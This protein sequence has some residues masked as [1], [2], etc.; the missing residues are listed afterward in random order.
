MAEENIN[1]QDIKRISDALLDELYSIGSGIRD[2]NFDV[3]SGFADVS[4]GMVKTENTLDLLSGVLGQILGQQEKY[5]QRQE[6]LEAERE[7]ADM[8][9]NTGNNTSTQIADLMK[10]SLAGFSELNIDEKQIEN[11]SGLINALVSGGKAWIDAGLDAGTVETIATGMGLISSAMTQ[12]LSSIP[13]DFSTEGVVKMTAGISGLETLVTEMDTAALSTGLNKVVEVFLDFK[14]NFPADVIG[15][16]NDF[17][18]NLSNIHIELPEGISETLTG[19]LNM[20]TTFRD[21][22]P[23]DALEPINELFRNLNNV[24]QQLNISGLDDI[25]SSVTKSFINF[26]DNFPDDLLTPLN[27]FL[28]DLSDIEQQFPT[29]LADNLSAITNVFIN[30]RDNFPTDIFVSV[31]EFFQR[32]NDM[33][34]N[35]PPE[36]STN[37]NGLLDTFRSFRDNFPTDITGHLNVFMENI[38]SL[39]HQFPENLISDINS[40][41]GTLMTFDREFPENIPDKI[42]ALVTRL[43]AMADEIEEIGERFSTKSFKKSIN[44]LLDVF[45][46]FKKEFPTDAMSVLTDFLK[47]VT[48]LRQGFPKN[49]GADINSLLK[50]LADF[51]KGVSLKNAKKS[52]KGLGEVLAEFMTKIPDEKGDSMKSLATFFA[53]FNRITPEQVKVFRSLRK[54]LTPAVAKSIKGFLD[55]MANADIPDAKQMKGV[56]DVIEAL[57]GAFTKVIVLL[58]VL[59]ILMMFDMNATLVAAATAVG[60]VAAMGGLVAGIAYIL[61]KKELNDSIGVIKS[62]SVAVL[63][64]VAC[65]GMMTLLA[66]VSETGDL[67]WGI[68]ITVG[69]TVLLVGMLHWLST[70]SKDIKDATISILAVSGAVVLLAGTLMFVSLMA[71]ILEATD[72]GWGILLFAVSLIGVGVVLKLTS[73][74]DKPAGEA[75]GALLAVGGMMVLLSISLMMFVMLA[76]NYDMED[77][78]AGILMLSVVVIGAWVL[79]RF[80]KIA[81]DSSKGAIN[82]AL[83]ISILILTLT[84]SL[85]LAVMIAQK[86][87]IGEILGGFAILALVVGMSIGLVWVLNKIGGRD[88]EKAALTMAIVVGLMLVTVGIAILMTYLPPMKD[89]ILEGSLIVGSILLAAVGITFMVA[90]IGKFAGDAM[91]KGVIGL[92]AVIGAIIALTIVGFYFADLVWRFA[93]I[94]WGMIGKTFTVIG[95]LLA[96]VTAILAIC[97][98]LVS[99]PQAA[100][101]GLAILGMYAIIGAIGALVWVTDSYLDLAER[102]SMLDETMLTSTRDTFTNIIMPGIGDMVSSFASLAGWAAVKAAAASVLLMPVFI[103]LGMFVDI[104]AKVATMTFVTGYDADGKPQYTTL[105]PEVFGKAAT[106]VSEGFGKFITELGKGFD[107]L[108]DKSIRAMDRLKWIMIPLMW[109]VSDFVDTV[110]KVATMQIID[111]Y[112]ENGKPKYRQV[113]TTVFSNAAEVVSGGFKD[114]IEKMG[115]GFGALEDKSI[116]A[117]KKLAKPMNKIMGAVKTFVDVVIKVATLRIVEGYDEKGNPIYGELKTRAFTMDENGVISQGEEVTGLAVFAVAGHAVAQSFGS[118]LRALTSA[119]DDKRTVDAIAKGTKAL[120]KNIRPIMKGIATFVDTIIKVATARVVTGYETDEHGNLIP[121][122]DVIKGQKIKVDSQGNIT[123]TGQ[124]EGY[125]AMAAAGETVAIMFTS[126]LN[127]LSSLFESR[128][129]QKQIERCLKSLKNVNPVMKGIGKFVD[130]ILKIATGT[131]PAF[132]ENGNALLDEEGN[133]KMRQINLETDL[134]N[135]AEV[136]AGAFAT[137]LTTL[138]DNLDK[139]KKTIKKVLESLKD[140][141]PVFESVGKFTD[142]IKVIGTGLYPIKGYDEQGNPIYDMTKQVDATSAANTLADTYTTFVNKIT[143][144]FNDES[145]KEKIKN[146]LSVITDTNTIVEKTCT[147]TSKIVEQINKFTGG[148]EG[149]GVKL[150]DLPAYSEKLVTNGIVKFVELFINSETIMNFPNYDMVAK[151]NAIEQ[152]LMA[153]DRGFVIYKRILDRDYSI[154]DNLNPF[155]MFVNSMERFANSTVANNTQ[156]FDKN[157]T[158]YRTCVDQM[159]ESLKKAQADIQKTDTKLQAFDKKAKGY[160]D[161]FVKYVRAVTTEIVNLDNQLIN[162]ERRRKQA[163]ESFA[164]GIKTVADELM[165]LNEQLM[166]QKGFSTMNDIA[167]NFK[168]AAEMMMEVQKSLDKVAEPMKKVAEHQV[169]SYRRPEVWDENR[170]RQAGWEATAR[171]AGLPQSLGGSVETQKGFS[172]IMS[173]PTAQGQM[174]MRFDSNGNMYTQYPDGSSFAIPANV[175]L[176]VYQQGGAE[177]L[178]NPMVVDRVNKDHGIRTPFPAGNQNPGGNGYYAHNPNPGGPADRF[179]AALNTREGVQ[180]VFNFDGYDIKGVMKTI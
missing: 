2:V 176:N 145:Y 16:V 65:I 96:G 159:T 119:F 162:N 62:I 85:M 155:T 108:S 64:L 88:M 109:T 34:T 125:G 157:L 76:K 98:A 170:R 144:T 43:D 148:D 23:A 133:P 51:D 94:E 83:G 17:F 139:N 92:A 169:E 89:D 68:G 47:A 44:E 160:S 78:G 121:I 73:M 35:F 81:G 27:K 52:L 126:F 54:V 95:A 1:K 101:F 122:M 178:T 18:V 179:N 128:E 30:F 172:E 58:G 71:K 136:I 87:D 164:E 141:T 41:L 154:G 150:N 115:E 26:R 106:V 123:V 100:V 104:V 69:V 113:E 165:A 132:D 66:S 102:I 29:D 131:V 137:F 124:T 21:N 74:L 24:S 3:S 163:T 142:A 118:F 171:Q 129:Q 60:M 84:V 151:A 120:G 77:I 42:K 36:L 107:S 37:I 45:K 49:L 153:I 180:V 67:L 134:T 110:I 166:N 161:N 80:A 10:S 93:G 13:P 112:D 56:V 63:L 22:F 152:F 38:L 143:A 90:L 138:A 25:L 175:V 57:S 140:V 72:I 39:S 20:F 75:V 111:G 5:I 55:I 99:G 149:T 135:P 9:G 116:N 19:I 11:V 130:A 46:K 31:N 103:T 32:L 105:D 97:A 33:G 15:L 91:M 53:N 12:L 79:A 173:A 7:Q 82:S 61:P 8:S 117:I 28:R 59:T 156:N 114:F 147:S 40:L 4:T 174:Q 158:L 168:K 50:S 48:D 167:D 14:Q 6:E 86:Y 146:T 177:A 70:F 127:R